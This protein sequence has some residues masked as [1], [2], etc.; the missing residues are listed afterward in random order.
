MSSGVQAGAWAWGAAVDAAAG[1]ASFWSSLRATMSVPGC[2][3]AGLEAGLEVVV[4]V[5]GVAASL[6]TAAFVAGT[7]EL[8]A[9]LAAGELG[10]ALA[11]LAGPVVTVSAMV[12][13]SLGFSVLLACDV[14]IHIY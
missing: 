10:A 5:P 13:G 4:A 1:A 7:A 14:K 12:D 8:T 11:G 6:G 3:G 9:E 2:P